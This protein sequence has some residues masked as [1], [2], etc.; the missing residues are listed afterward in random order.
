MPALGPGI[1][2]FTP[3]LSDL[4]FLA[5]DRDLPGLVELGLGGVLQDGAGA[6]VDDEGRLAA[7]AP[8]LDF[9]LGHDT[10]SERERTW[11]DFAASIAPDAAVTTEAQEA[12][13]SPKALT[14]AMTT[15]R[16]TPRRGLLQDAHA[17]ERAL[18]IL[19]WIGLCAVLIGT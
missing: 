9:L 1:R 8:D 19:L 3:G 12:I 10:F 14:P 4:H 5:V 17:F 16:L 13:P 15:P 11:R 18:G 6:D 7:G 2:L